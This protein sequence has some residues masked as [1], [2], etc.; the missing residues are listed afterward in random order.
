MRFKLPFAKSAPAEVTSDEADAAVPALD[1]E[2]DHEAPP[3][4]SDPQEGSTAQTQG[5]EAL[6]AKARGFR[7]LA[8]K[9]RMV[10]AV[11]STIALITGI[12]AF[13]YT[14]MLGAVAKEVGGS[15]A[16]MA[17]AA[18][19]MQLS[20]HDGRVLLADSLYDGRADEA[21]IET[22]RANFAKS[23]RLGEEMLRDLDAVLDHDG[24]GL[25]SDALAQKLRNDIEAALLDLGTLERLSEGYFAQVAAAKAAAANSA[26]PAQG[27][28]SEYERLSTALADLSRDP[29]IIQNARAQALMGEARTQMALGHLAVERMIGGAGE[30]QIGAVQAIFATVQEKI[31]EASRFGGGRAFSAAAF[32]IALLSDLALDLDERSR[33][34]RTAA[35]AGRTEFINTFHSFVEASDVVKHSMRSLISKGLEVQAT[36]QQR[37][38]ITIVLGVGSFLIVA[39]LT[40][41]LL[42]ARFIN[43]LI[44]LSA[45]LTA[46][47]KGD[48][49]VA[50]PTWHSNDEMGDLRDVVL[51]FQEALEARAALEEQSRSALR[52]LEAKDA[53]SRAAAAE[54]REQHRKA[55]EQTDEI[56][57][58]QRETDALTA[59]LLQIV[60]QVTKGDMDGAMGETWNTPALG[61]LAAS[62][63][64]LTG[65]LRG[66]FAEIN[67]VVGALSD[68]NLTESF[69]K[70]FTG[71]FGETQDGIMR[72][73]EGLSAMIGEIRDSGAMVSLRAGEI[74]SV[75]QELA[76]QT[77]TQA[78]ALSELSATVAQI[79][80]SVKDNAA[81]AAAARSSVQEVCHLSDE[82]STV[83]ERT[84]D[85]VRLIA[86]SGGKIVS[87]V[88]AIE[89]IAFQTNILALNA[90][91][92]AARAGEAG[93]G[94]S[95]VAAEVRGLAHKTS[96]A[97]DN[98]KGLIDESQRNVASGVAL[99]D[100][101]GTK[102]S[103]I[104][105]AIDA[106]EENIRAV[107]ASSSEQSRAISEV[108]VA[109]DAIDQDV[110]HGTTLT[111]NCEEAASDLSGQA[112]ALEQ[113]VERF[114]LA[115]TAGGAGGDQGFAGDEAR[116]AAARRRAAS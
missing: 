9:A 45:T 85:A 69:D 73:V 31:N 112:A 28:A 111:A 37:L 87:I 106:L 97:A 42:R 99:A 18:K 116:R 77:D 78:A 4:Q 100:E 94:F 103:D 14:I 33:A 82:G 71:A 72:T 21:M 114:R 62:M 50:A 108:A 67:H 75:A 46:L 23:R 36:M 34:Q 86:E 105:R 20:A 95:V 27:Y 29:S 115:P 104:R 1:H 41:T 74:G 39:F 64:S 55:Q 96:D 5:D 91:V 17:D 107:D 109:I 66:V 49:D 16:P 59:E 53:E 63:N 25:F 38:V 113:L 65:E 8:G 84:K 44:D 98:I 15:L 93:K 52:D 83:V 51:R 32:D 90:S 3:L 102:I 58:R 61:Q 81:S 89:E 43:R 26:Q 92:E 19:E 68:A 60:D 10:L 22:V 70:R 7:S 30:V 48:M 54:L 79:N 24:A 11:F 2:E 47:A 6:P 101:A 76:R 40:Y 80:D 56:A 13:A 57:E 88:N 110:Q 12:A 35:A